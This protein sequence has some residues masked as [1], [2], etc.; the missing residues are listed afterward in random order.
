MNASFTFIVTIKLTLMIVVKAQDEVLGLIS[1]SGYE[2][3]VHQVE[4]EDGYLLNIHRVLP[5]VRSASKF[6]AFLQHGLL[7]TA[8]DYLI[9]GP[10]IA[11]A[12]LLADNGYDVWLGN[13]RGNKYSANHISLSKDST[14]FWNFS[15]H[16][17][18]F[19][20]LPAMIDCMLNTTMT[21]KAFYVGHSQGGTTAMV[22]LS[23][24]PEFNQKIIQAHLMGPAV[25]MG[26]FP[27]YFVKLVGAEIDNGL[28]E[29]YAFLNFE[30][31]WYQANP[32]IKLLCN[33]NKT[34]FCEWLTFAMFGSNKEEVEIE[35]VSESS[36]Q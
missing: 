6:P 32:L 15:W 5:K 12:F 25:F 1:S 7:A 30:D 33:E 36:S 17:I 27:H 35:T 10:N 19:Y 3:E 24:R 21:Q 22:L 26:N 23:M 11:L 9:T 14:A 34:S 13:A 8:T 18:G 28:L 4:T 2:G 16:E 20:D 31:V 29:D